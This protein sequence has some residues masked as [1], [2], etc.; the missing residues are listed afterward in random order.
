LVPSLSVLLP[1]HNAESVLA[2]QVCR[3]LEVLPDLAERF[4]IL[5]VDD[6]STDQTPELAGELTERFPQLRLLRHGRRRGMSAAIAAGMGATSGEFVVVHE[7]GEPISPR[8]LRRLWELRHDEDLVV[9]RAESRP[10]LIDAGLISRLLNWGRGVE[11]TVSEGLPSGTQ[12]LRRSAVRELEANPSLQNLRMA[13]ADGAEKIARVVP[14][15]KGVGVVAH[16][17]DF[18]LGE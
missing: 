12:L 6:G 15:R 4:E 2:E 13:R 9:A 3:L 10:A 14:R 18:A 17:R 1:V 5:I 7:G 8:D 16:L 11:R